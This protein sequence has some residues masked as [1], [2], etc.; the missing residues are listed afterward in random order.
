MATLTHLIK[1]T[2]TAF[3]VTLTLTTASFAQETV[4]DGLFQDL[5]EA[6]IENHDRIAERIRNEFGKSGSAS[7]DLLL[8]RGQDAFFQDGE[9]GPA[10]EHFTAAI[11]HAPDFAEAYLLRSLA[12]YELGLVGPALSDLEQALALNPRHFEAMGRLASYLMEMERYD[13][14]QRVVNA[15]QAVYP[16]HEFAAEIQEQLTFIE[17]GQAL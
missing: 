2:V 14:A 7:I 9:A 4:L 15:L 13:E 10:S 3:A 6:N 5:N 8:R 16:L 12:Y 11:D 1:R 17:Q